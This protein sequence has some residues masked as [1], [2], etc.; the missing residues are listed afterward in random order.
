MS[1]DGLGKDTNQL[2]QVLHPV[3]GSDGFG[4]GIG[5]KFLE[6]VY[7]ADL[8]CFINMHDQ[9]FTVLCFVQLIQRSG[10]KKPWL[11]P[12]IRLISLSSQD[13]RN[14]SV[15]AH[16]QLKRLGVLPRPHESRVPMKILIRPRH[17]GHGGCR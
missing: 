4:I 8:H 12:S 13:F 15:A 6:P 11:P 10:Y 14:P 7:T 9:A 2:L 1:V 17:G 3:A 5:G 16:W